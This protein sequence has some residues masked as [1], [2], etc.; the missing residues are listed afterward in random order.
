MR[1]VSVVLAAIG[2]GAAAGLWSAAAQERPS[3][4][5]VERG[6]LAPPPASAGG[7]APPEGAAAAG[8]NFGPWRQAEPGAYATAFE[9]QIRQRYADGRSAAQVR[10]DLEANGFLCEAGRRLDCRI[11]VVER[12]CAYDWYV[13]LEE[14]RRE[15]IVGFDQAC[16][17]RAG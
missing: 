15:P 11:E 16:G 6:T 9:A 10:A 2:V 14:G 3:P 8:I 12:Q 4:F 1:L 17:V 13:V 7:P 5:P